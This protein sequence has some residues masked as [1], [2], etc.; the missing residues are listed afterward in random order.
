MPT[1]PPLPSRVARLPK[2]ERGFPVPW[3]VQWFENGEPS[4]FGVGAPDFRVI[5]S[6]KMQTALR[7]PRC[8]VCGEQMGVH[9][10]FLIGPMCAINR[11]ISEPPSHR[12]CAEFAAKACPFLANP[13]MRRN[14]KDLPE[15]E[16]AAG[17]GLKRNPKAVCLWETKNYRPF[18]AH[19]GNA[20]ILFRLGEPERVDWYAMGRAATR[21]EVLESID[22]GYPELE[23]LA[24]AD[25][26]EAVAALEQYRARVLPLLPCSPS[27]TM[28]GPK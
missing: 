28:G 13:R 25:G 3:F 23:R 22:S 24:L 5:D 18:K 12:E 1:L 8:W 9:R 17:F 19:A 16:A 26:P 10:V 14:E 20:G 15:G 7:Q 4:D 21:A 6:R 27:S 11:V 2:D